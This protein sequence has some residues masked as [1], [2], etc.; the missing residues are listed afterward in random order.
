MKSRLLPPPQ[1]RAVPA[2]R[3]PGGRHGGLLGIDPCG[4]RI[5][6]RASARPAQIGAENPAGDEIED[7]GAEQRSRQE[8]GKQNPGDTSAGP[9]N[10]ASTA[11]SCMICAEEA[12]RMRK[13]ACS[14]RRRVPPEA[15]TAVV[16]RIAN[17]APGVPRNRNS[18]L[19]VER[20]LAHPVEARRKVV[21]NDAVAGDAGL[22]ILR[23]LLHRDKGATGSLGKPVVRESD[24][25]LGSN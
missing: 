22:E 21:G 23:R 25:E 11:A 4:S 13:S 20:I 5:A 12:P 6:A 9:T 14:R 10:A 17:T 16:S 19:G 15:A 3:R 7:A 1:A 18:D 2:R 8:L 24:V